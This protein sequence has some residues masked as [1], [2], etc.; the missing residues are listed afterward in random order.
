[1]AIKRCY[2]LRETI[3]NNFDQV[4]A[5]ADGVVFEFRASRQ[6]DLALRKRILHWELN[7]RLIFVTRI[8]LWKYRVPLP[9]LELPDPVPRAQQDFDD[10]LAAV[11]DALADQMEGKPPARYPDL[12]D[13]VERLARTVHASVGK[14]PQE[15]LATRLET[16][17]SLSRRIESLTVSL[18]QEMG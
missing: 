15:L 4:R 11:L 3:N 5:L 17:L 14:E 10:Q 1:V 8:V 13:A 12:E 18:E 2:S 9:G 7:M 16:F 6:Q